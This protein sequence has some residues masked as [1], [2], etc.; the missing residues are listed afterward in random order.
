MNGISFIFL[1]LITS[2]CSPLI[3]KT[4]LKTE[5]HHDALA[6]AVISFVLSGLYALVF[7]CI[8]SFNMHDFL[9]LQNSHI[10][11]LILLDIFVWALGSCVF[12]PGYKHLPVSEVTITSSLQGMFA[13][14]FGLLLF[15]TESFHIFRLVGGI[16]AVSSVALMNQENGKWKYNKFTFA[17]ILGTIVFGFATVV[18]N[19]II[20]HRYFSSVVF[21]MI[22]NFGLTAL[23]VILLRPKTVKSIPHVLKDKK[24]FL[25]VCL[26]SLVSS[27]TFFFVY[28]AYKYHIVASQSYL[29]LSTQTVFVVILGSVLFKEETNMHKKIIAGI[30]ATIGVYLIS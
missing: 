7:Y 12:Y 25:T 29:I 20:A 15:K 18:D 28:N 1:A 17:L 16:L 6:Y 24:A 8:T 21:L 4:V 9:L 5:S 22:C 23:C 19:V 11:L 2:I 3:V 26:S 13:L 27:L 30:I 14:L 10:A